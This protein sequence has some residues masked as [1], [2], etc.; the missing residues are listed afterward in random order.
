M[1]TFLIGCMQWEDGAFS[2][3]VGFGGCGIIVEYRSRNLDSNFRS[4]PGCILEY[5]T[6][7][8]ESYIRGRLDTN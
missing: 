5:R 3:L 8:L 2:S 1:N 7:R 4:G 6:S